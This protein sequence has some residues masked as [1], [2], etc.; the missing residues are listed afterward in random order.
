MSFFTRLGSLLAAMLF[1]VS[2][3]G[4]SVLCYTDGKPIVAERQEYCY[5]NCKLLI[6]GYYGGL[7]LGQLAADAGLDFVIESSVT[8]ELLDEY[9]DCGVGVIAGGYNLPR[10]YATAD[11]QLIGKWVN[12][13]TLQYKDHPALWGD[14]LIDEPD[15]NYYDLLAKAVN[16]HKEKHPDKMCYINL[17][18][19]YASPEQLGIQP[20]LNF[21]QKALL[22]FTDH[23]VTCVDTYKGYVSDYINKINTDY[24]CVDFYPYSF[25]K[26]GK[27]TT[28]E[29]YL[30]NLDILAEACR[31]TD[32]DLWVITQ[33]AG[34][35]QTNDKADMRWCEDVPEISQQCY[36]SLAFGAK[37][38]VHAEFAA[39]GWWDADSHMI[40]SDGKPT[41]TYQS[42]AKVN[43]YLKAFAEEYGRYSYTSTYLIHKSK[44]AGYRKG[45]LNVTIPGE[46]ADISSR[47][48]L[49]VGTFTGDRNSKAYVIEYICFAD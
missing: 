42:V 20:K 28:Q 18:P 34:L 40:G 14:D 12:Q 32:R 39:K 13:D 23:Y 30:R 26:K 10:F 41:K 6:G 22:L 44:V 43:G 25:N 1:A 2:G 8:P 36:V 15:A 17:F 19:I 38:L 31:S 29:Y 11:E 35:T 21:F 49:V 24:I 3:I 16:A 9:E 7:G 47:N 37:A 5:D 48:G 4:Q 46:K 33:A 45:G 27:K